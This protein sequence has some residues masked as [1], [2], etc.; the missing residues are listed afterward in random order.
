MACVRGWFTHSQVWQRMMA[1][2]RD[3]RW[4]WGGNTFA[5]SF[6]GATLLPYESWIPRASIPREEESLEQLYHLLRLNLE[7]QIVTSIWSQAHPD[8]RG[9]SASYCKKYLW[10]L[11][12]I[13]V[14]IFG[15]YDL[16][17]LYK[18]ILCC[19]DAVKYM[20]DL[21]LWCLEHSS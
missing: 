10:G 8:P 6:S 2:S 7:I 3:F 14:V 18:V 16:H 1:V 20:F 19:C 12:Y 21:C 9:V 15:K 13:D 4:V 11:I 17:I 5:K